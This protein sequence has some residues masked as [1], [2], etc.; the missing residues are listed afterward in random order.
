MDKTYKRQFWI[1]NIPYFALVLLISWALL[2]NSWKL[3]SIGF[4]AVSLF[5]IYDNFIELERL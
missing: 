2:H 4:V 3:L 5:F 1:R